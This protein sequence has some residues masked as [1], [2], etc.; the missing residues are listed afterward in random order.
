MFSILCSIYL[1]DNL[2]K[3]K[4]CCSGLLT[5]DFIFLDENMYRESL[6]GEGRKL[7]M[8]LFSSSHSRKSDFMNNVKSDIISW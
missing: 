4:I 3:I 8:S 1:I 6:P 2:D 5:A 7:R